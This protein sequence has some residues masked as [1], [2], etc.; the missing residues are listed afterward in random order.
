MSPVKPVLHWRRFKSE[1]WLSHAQQDI[2][3]QLIKSLIRQV[4][5]AHGGAVK[6]GRLELVRRG[7]AVAIIQPT[8]AAIVGVDLGQKGL[9]LGIGVELRG[10]FFEDQIGAHTAAGEMP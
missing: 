6:G 8:A 7:S 9:H 10:L 1:K 5:R 2:K 3:G 4:A